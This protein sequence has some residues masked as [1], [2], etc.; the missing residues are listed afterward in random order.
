M[1]E[2][3]GR[4]RSPRK[5]KKEDSMQRIS[6]MGLAYAGALAAAMLFLTPDAQATAWC[7]KES[8]NVI[9]CS[10]CSKELSCDVWGYSL[11]IT[12]NNVNLDGKGRYSYYAPANGVDIY[13]YGSA[14]KNL[15]VDHAGKHGVAIQGVAVTGVA[16]LID[17]VWVTYPGQVG[18]YINST[19]PAAVTYSQVLN[20]GNVGASASG[21]SKADFNHCAISNSANVG[22]MEASGGSSLLTNVIS[23]NL[24]HGAQ[25]DGATKMVISGN[26]FD[27]N[28]GLGLYMNNSGGSVKYNSGNNNKYYD[29]YEAH[30]RPAT[31]IT[32]GNSW[33]THSGVGC[34]P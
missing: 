11:V 15:H 16:D 24:L 6:I 12:G 2:M 21:P 5:A 30:D 22:L 1:A 31:F 4:S 20:A 26:H 28:Q 9:S 23:G 18:I 8:D 29:C 17:H 14:V 33:G 19:N 27:G 3:R 32:G 7:P 34:Q 25:I 10:N 13:G